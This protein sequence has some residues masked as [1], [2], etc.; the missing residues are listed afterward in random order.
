MWNKAFS[1]TPY[2]PEGKGQVERF[3]STLLSMLHTLPED[4]KSHWSD[5]VSKVVHA[6]NCTKNEATGY[7]PFHLLFGRSPHLPIDL[8][9]NTSP[10]STPAKHKEFVEEWKE[11]MQQAYKLASEKVSKSTTKPQSHYKRKATFTKLLP[12]DRV[13]VRN[14]ETGGPGKLRAFWE[15]K[16]YIVTEQLDEDSPVYEV[17]PEEKKGKSKVLHRNLLLPCDYLPIPESTVFPKNSR[18]EKKCTVQQKESI[19]IIRYLMSCQ[20]MKMT[21]IAIMMRFHLSC[22]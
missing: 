15:D 7:S 14:Q 22:Q 3:N 6:Y 9:F 8:I 13:F 18:N 19:I 16:V 4:K 17:K 5:H 2:H 11:A 1:Q 10:L 20:N 12:R 21:Q